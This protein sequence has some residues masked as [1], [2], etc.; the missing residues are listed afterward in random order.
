MGQ[1]Y[2][3]ELKRILSR[4]G[5]QFVRYGKGDHEIWYSP[6][7]NRHISIDAGT[8]KRFTATSALKQAGIEEKIK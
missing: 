5:C 1:G 6:I 8:K 2:G 3:R 7:T 4:H